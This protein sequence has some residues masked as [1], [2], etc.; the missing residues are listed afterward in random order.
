MALT[1]PPIYLLKT[2]FE[3]NADELHRLEKEIDVVWDIKEAKLVIG[4]VGTKKRAAHELRKLGLY[5]EDVQEFAAQGEKS[6]LGEDFGP[7]R[8]RRKL[9]R[10]EGASPQVISLD[11]ETES[12][13]DGEID[14]VAK[15]FSNR[16]D[17]PTVKVLRLAWY[18]DSVK[19]GELMPME[20]YLV[21]E[22]AI[23]SG[24][25][26]EVTSPKTKLPQ[27]QTIF[28]RA[29]EDTPPRVSPK[30]F[31]RYRSKRPEDHHARSQP[32]LLHETTTEHE[33]YVE[34]PPLPS[35]LVHTPYCCQRPTP[36][37]GPNEAFLSQL[38]VLQK[39]RDLEGEIMR[40]RAYNH[41]IAAIAA[42]PYTI[43]LA[44]EIERLP[45]C[46]D[47][48]A[49]LWQEWNDTGHNREVDEIKSD[50]DI[51]IKEIFYGIHGVGHIGAREFFEKGWKD[52][53]DV[54][55][56]GWGSLN[57]EQQAGVKFWD[58]F[59][60][61]I[62]RQEVESIAQVVL[63]AANEIR[64]GFQMVIAG[65]YRRG[66]PQSGDVDVIL[67]H[68]DENATL[69][70]LG[71]LLELLNQGGWITHVLRRSLHNS[72][73]NQKPLPWRGGMASGGAGKS[74]FD[75]LDKAFLAWQNPEW[76]TME[77]D[78][79][80]DPDAPNPNLHRRVDIIISPWKTAGCA[81]IGWS[82]GTMFQR[83]L[84]GYCKKE[85][86]MKFDSSGIRRRGNGEWMDFERGE[87]DL[88][89]KEKRVFAGL[90][91]E[92]REPTERCTD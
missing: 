2:H 38:R 66:K 21:Y 74:G 78:L 43:T 54:V 59:Q 12:D 72:E 14:T 36:L 80:K 39:A 89:A 73:R 5:T 6:A 7:A 15:S 58:D 92:W 31:N 60:Q 16:K 32:P 35:Y 26:P 48:V 52:L 33:A 45:H 23:V 41:S 44:K 55:T 3:K 90:N 82:G 76:P 64:T 9:S 75:T 79:E 19:A 17:I 69:N 85:L 91:L 61:K 81:I 1:F 42:Y 62:P 65:G 88:L 83:D 10:N 8:K 57:K 71:E 20:K 51:K 77:E 46:G 84:R 70:L 87:D 53:D 49:R 24:L 22:G 28:T 50:P 13:A 40:K 56:H 4:L 67:T 34:L 25:K 30:S 86:D 27:K 63:Q 11:S 47:K 68:P 29:K 37:H 18:T